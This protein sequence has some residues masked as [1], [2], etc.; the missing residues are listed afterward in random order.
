MRPSPHPV[1]HVAT[2]NAGKLRDF[3]AAAH[4]YGVEIRPLPGFETLAPVEEDGAT[5]EQNARK[6]AQRYSFALTGEVVI[7]DDSGLE[8]DALGGAPGVLSA[9]YA[10]HLSGDG[11]VAPNFSDAA[12][13]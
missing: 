11:T 1:I 5:F 2:S 8:V 7:T 12:N 13:N 9:R 6:K 3:A 10:A 4:E